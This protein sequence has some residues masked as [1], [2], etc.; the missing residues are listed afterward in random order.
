MSRWH[1][2]VAAQQGEEQERLFRH[3]PGGDPAEMRLAYGEA[4]L[5]EQDF[6]GNQGWAAPVVDPGI[7]AAGIPG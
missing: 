7:G 3:G 4:A 6:A 5:P 2:A 1:P